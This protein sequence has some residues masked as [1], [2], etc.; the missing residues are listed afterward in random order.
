MARGND[1]HPTIVIRKVKKHAHAGHHGGAWKVAYA[2]F[3]TAMM[4]FFM[5][6]W[7]LANPDKEQLKGLAEYFS[8]N[9][10]KSSPATT[11]TSLPGSQAGLGGHSRRNQS[12]DSE[13]L[14][15][16]SAEAGTK[17][18]ARGGTADI[19]EAALRVMAQ[20]MQ[21]SLDPPVDPS[22]GKRNI[23]VEPDRDGFRIHLMDNAN[24]SMF[25]GGTAELNDYA[26][27]L[28]GR[29]A[30]KLAGTGAQVAIEGHTDST[31]GQSEANWT[32]SAQRALS[33]RAAMVASGLPADRFAEVV[34]KAGTEPVYP[35][36][37][38]RPENRRITIVVMAEPSALPRDA[39]FKF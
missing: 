37:P 4:A 34:A 5:L 38:D 10:E 20:E 6:L 8:P 31:G 22:Q 12:S 33:A 9:A 29:I 25:K 3:V 27:N 23:D 16:P 24:R 14:G 1:E 30:R 13:A 2:D 19:P 28:L 39:S 21:L 36:R 15:E 17:G 11:L 18:A 7:L 32:L 26:R 35:D